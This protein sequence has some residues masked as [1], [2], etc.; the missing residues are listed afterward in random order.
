MPARPSSSTQALLAK[1]PYAAFVLAI[2][3]GGY[4][5]GAQSSRDTEA[6]AGAGTGMRAHHRHSH[7]HMNLQGGGAHTAHAEGE[8]LGAL[9][10][11]FDPSIGMDGPSKK[12]QTEVR[13]IIIKAQQQRHLCRTAGFTASGGQQRRA[14]RRP[15]TAGSARRPH[16]QT[17]GPADR[18]QN[19]G[20]HSSK[21]T[22]RVTQSYS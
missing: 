1:L 19:G 16:R 5:L 7:S 17:E 8:D 12:Q 21:G 9:H 20:W 2:A 14:R 11:H 6:A 18:R 22:A 3:I 10:A 15:D 13:Q 4:L